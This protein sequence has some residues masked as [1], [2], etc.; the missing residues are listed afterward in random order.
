MVR[1]TIWTSLTATCLAQLVY[2]RSFVWEFVVQF[3]AGP[4]LRVLKYIVTEE[5]VLPLL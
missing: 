3:L 4:T 1:T 5:K 2:H